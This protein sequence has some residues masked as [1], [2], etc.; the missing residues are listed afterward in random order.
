[1]LLVICV[2]VDLPN[3]VVICVVVDP[4]NVV[5]ICVVD[6]SICVIG[7][8][9]YWSYVLLVIC[10]IRSRDSKDNFLTSLLV[11]RTR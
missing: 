1:M 10:V 3:E 7:H 8:M 6:P 9:C 11:C 4:L 2:F 5:V